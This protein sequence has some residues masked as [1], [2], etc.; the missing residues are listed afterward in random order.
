LATAKNI[1]ETGNLTE[2]LQHNKEKRN[3][4]EQTPKNQD[5]T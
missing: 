3:K 1:D 5:R 2:A 4:K